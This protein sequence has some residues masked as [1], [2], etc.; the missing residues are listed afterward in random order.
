MF[1]VQVFL[2]IASTG[3]SGAQPADLERLQKELAVQFGGVTAYVHQP[4]EG[5]WRPN[6]AEVVR[7]S[8]VLFEVMVEEL[9]S[10]WWAKW[11]REVERRFGQEELLIRALESTRL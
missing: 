6:S 11:R 5:L 2:P 3:Q 8:L 10:R 1:L 4:A 9:D 7:D